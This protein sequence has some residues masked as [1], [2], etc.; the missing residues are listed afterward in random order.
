[1][2]RDSGRVVCFPGSLT[3]TC[4][5]LQQEKE[6]L[7]AVF[8]G[9]LQK[10]QEKHQQELANIEEQ[11]QAFY[12]AE[13]EKVHEAYQEQADR[14]RSQMLQEVRSEMGRPQS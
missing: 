5:R 3:A 8:Q 6:E 11:Q 13:W 10:V 4:D 12:S 1:M 2:S 7:N 14:C 9:A